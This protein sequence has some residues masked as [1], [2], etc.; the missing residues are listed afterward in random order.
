MRFTSYIG[1]L[2]LLPGAVMGSVLGLRAD[3]CNANVRHNRWRLELA[4]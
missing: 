4:E 1:A 2:G 3:S